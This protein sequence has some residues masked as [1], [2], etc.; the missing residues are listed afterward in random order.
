VLEE[1]KFE[2]AVVE[3]E[4]G[5]PGL[6]LSKDE[7]SGEAVEKVVYI[8]RCA[9]VVK[10]GRRFSFSALVVVGDGKGKVGC[11]LGK[12]NEVSDAIRKGTEY[13]KKSMKNVC[14]RGT[15]IPHE[16]FSKFD[17]GRV[18]LRPATKGTGIIAGGG[19]RAVLEAAGVKDVLAKSMGSSNPI[20]VV[21]A[22]MR[23]LESMRNLSMIKEMRGV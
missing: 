8:N 6:P 16:I 17:G 1:E 22:T 15:T 12:A 4:K 13:A 18:L 19:V 7:P 3:E 23:C 14:L 2:S 10:G 21:K 20:N 5:K 11:G 9:K